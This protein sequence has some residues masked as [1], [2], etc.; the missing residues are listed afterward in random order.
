MITKLSSIDTEASPNE[1]K[2]RISQDLQMMHDKTMESFPQLPVRDCV[3]LSDESYDMRMESQPEPPSQGGMK[4][5]GGG[6]PGGG[7]K[8]V[9]GVSANVT[10]KVRAS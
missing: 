5:W 6:A 8:M 7:A 9:L 4:H 2:R 10:E 1:D 3:K